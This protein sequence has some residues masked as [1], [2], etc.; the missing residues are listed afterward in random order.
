MG[1]EETIANEY[2]AYADVVKALEPVLDGFPG[3]LVAIDGYPLA[4]KSTLGRY[5][6]WRFQVSLIE[7]DWFMVRGQGRFEYRYDELRRVLDHRL[8][9]EDPE[10]NRPVLVD[11][12]VILRVLDHLGLKPNFSIRLKRAGLP[13][14]VS[15]RA[16]YARYRREF[17]DEK[18]SL[19]VQL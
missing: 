5:L 15:L 1:S 10:A 18:V 12:A 3:V 4:G 17:P 16:E 8:G 13:K 6:A 19:V 14:Y 7:T 11:G 9:R 2:P